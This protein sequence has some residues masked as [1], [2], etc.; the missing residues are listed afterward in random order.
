MK[1]AAQLF[2]VHDFTKNLEDFEKSLKK[3]ADIGYKYVQVSGTCAYEAG[4]LKEK[5]DK[6]GLKCCLTHIS[7]DKLLNETDLVIDE[8]N[9][10]DCKYIGIGAL[11]NIW[12]KAFPRDKAVSDFVNNYT[13]VAKKFKD[14]GKYFMYHNHHFEFER[15]K[16]SGK[17]MIDRLISEIAP[18]LMGF[19]VDTYWVQY[20]GMNVVNFIK[21][22]KGRCPIVHFK[23][24]AVDISDETNPIHMSP[25]GSGNI[26]FKEVIKACEYAGT[27]FVCVEQDNCYGEDPFV[28]L[29]K[30]YKHLKELGLE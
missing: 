25:C 7:P 14:A 4:W 29:E 16:E 12:D 27:E 30:S 21:N 6:Y 11:P 18:E 28:C 19:T 15:G 24:Y 2:T 9:T 17:L 8:H 13:S 10:F 1:I 23:D 5:L 3:V 22:L 26:D 20:G